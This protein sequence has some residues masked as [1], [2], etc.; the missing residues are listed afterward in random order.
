MPLPAEKFYIPGSLL[1]AA[2]DRAHPL[3]WGMRDHAYVF[4]DESRAFRLPPD[5]A[6]RGVH[7]VAWY[8]SATPL[9]S[10]WA[11][12]QK[13]LDR[14]AAIVDARLGAGHVVLYGAEVAWRAQPHGTFRL[15]FNA[16]LP[17]SA[18]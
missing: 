5:A 3:A 9:K 8:D 17:T 18:P 6:A 10:G 4:F 7:A 14:A 11:W 15:L 2:V 13:Y 1:E 12:G 16:L